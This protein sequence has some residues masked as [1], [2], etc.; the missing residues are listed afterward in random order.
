[1]QAEHGD[2]KKAK[3]KAFLRLGEHLG[4]GSCFGKRRSPFWLPGFSLVLRF[5][6][7]IFSLASPAPQGLKH[8]PALPPAEKQ[9]E[10]PH[11]ASLPLLV[12]SNPQPSPH[13]P[14]HS[15]E[16]HLPS[17]WVSRRCSAGCNPACF[18]FQVTRRASGVRRLLGDSSQGRPGFGRLPVLPPQALGV[19]GALG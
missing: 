16:W 17:C 13:P 6:L 2:G 10:K 19:R 8:P 15:L 9:R 1:M 12:S 14:P 4:V 7:Q 3:W 18:P 5:S 11:G